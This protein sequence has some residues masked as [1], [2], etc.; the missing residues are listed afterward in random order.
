MNQRSSKMILTGLTLLLITNASVLGQIKGYA[1]QNVLLPCNCSGYDRLAWQKDDKLLS[2]YPE[3]KNIIAA[4]YIG[5]TQLFLNNEKTNCSLL[6]LNI[7]HTDSG[8]YQCYVIVDVQTGVGRA[9]P[10][11]VNLA[12]LSSAIGEPETVPIPRIVVVVVVILAVVVLLTL[13]GRRWHR[14]NKASYLPTQ[15]AVTEDV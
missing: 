10:H 15:N 9:T 1:G 14:K 11:E 6:L 8:L 2:S 4:E 13:L 3:E 12:V 5:R 7:S